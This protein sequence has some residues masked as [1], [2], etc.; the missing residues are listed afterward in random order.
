MGV[1]VRNVRAIISPPLVACLHFAP[2]SLAFSLALPR[3]LLGFHLFGFPCCPCRL[4]MVQTTRK[5]SDAEV[6]LAESAVVSSNSFMALCARI[7]LFAGIISAHSSFYH[8]LLSKLFTLLRIPSWASQVPSEI[9]AQFF[10]PASAAFSSASLL[11][12]FPASLGSQTS[13]LWWSVICFFSLQS[14]P[15]ATSLQGR[16]NFSFMNTCGDNIFAHVFCGCE[17]PSP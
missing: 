10:C 9:S 14:L 5:S 16:W 6:S 17:C 15:V 4:K 1:P 8:P 12:P 11:S 2:Y 13:V 7:L 3:L